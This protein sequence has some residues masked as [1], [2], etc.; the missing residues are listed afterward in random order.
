MINGIRR[1]YYF[2]IGGGCAKK[3]MVLA[4]DVA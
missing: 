1:G 2:N 4:E 3:S